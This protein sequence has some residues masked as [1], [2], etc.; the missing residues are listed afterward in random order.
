VGLLL[1]G[2]AVVGLNFK[3]NLL[4]LLFAGLVVALLLISSYIGL[5]RFELSIIP[6]A[7]GWYQALN[8]IE[9]AVQRA[10]AAVLPGAILAVLLMIWISILW[11]GKLRDINRQSPNISPEA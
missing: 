7:V 2:I 11:S 4:Y 9:D 10:Y 3:E 5:V 8:V 6:I 1:F